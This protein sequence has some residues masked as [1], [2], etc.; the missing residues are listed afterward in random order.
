MSDLFAGWLANPLNRGWRAA[1]QLVQQ[2]PFSA[3]QK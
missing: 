1:P 3:R 2:Y